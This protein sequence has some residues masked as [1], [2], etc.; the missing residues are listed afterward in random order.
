MTSNYQL[1]ILDLTFYGFFLNKMSCFGAQIAISSAVP[2]TFARSSLPNT[3][4]LPSSSG[5]ISVK[6]FNMEEEQKPTSFQTLTKHVSFVSTH[7]G[8]VRVTPG[9]RG[10]R[11][12]MEGAHWDAGQQTSQTRGR[13]ES[14][15]VYI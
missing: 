10:G 4:S 9:T 13:A 3:H 6:T 2:C 7:V 11:M 15:I 8:L 5:I 1:I 12:E 14:G